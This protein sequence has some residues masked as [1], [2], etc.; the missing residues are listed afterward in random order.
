MGNNKHYLKNRFTGAGKQN[1]GKLQSS[2]KFC[3]LAFKVE[4]PEAFVWRY[5]AG[6]WQF[7]SSRSKQHNVQ[8]L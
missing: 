7:P 2:C 4:K 5:Q 6:N 1:R 3:Y 8:K